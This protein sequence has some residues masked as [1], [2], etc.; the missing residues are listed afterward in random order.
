MSYI[1]I[2]ILKVAGI[3]VLSAAL[4]FLFIVLCLSFAFSPNPSYKE[5]ICFAERLLGFSLGYEHE[6][7]EFN[8]QY[9]HPDRPLHF[10]AKIPH[11]QFK[12]V[13][14]YCE[15]DAQQ[16]EEV[17][18]DDGKYITT[19]SPLSF[20]CIDWK[21]D[22]PEYGYMKTRTVRTSGVPVFIQE[23]FVNVDKGQIEYKH[24]GC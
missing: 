21:R 19:E 6:F 16:Q 5:S 10:V 8:A 24:F 4:V 18:T 12:K 13:V 11:E 17:T 3:L 20:V 22:S 2:F 1:I 15:K 9:G 14:E 7:I 23:L